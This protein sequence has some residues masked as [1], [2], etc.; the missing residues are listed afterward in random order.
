MAAGLAAVSA[1]SEGH[2]GAAL[3]TGGSGVA[4]MLP[5]T[6]AVVK[7][8]SRAA[9]CYSASLLFSGVL[10]HPVLKLLYAEGHQYSKAKNTISV[11]DIALAA[12]MLISVRCLCRPGPIAQNSSGNVTEGVGRGRGGWQ[13][14]ALRTAAPGLLVFGSITLST[15]AVV[16][17]FWIFS[18]L[19]PLEIVFVVLLSRLWQGVVPTLGQAT[20]VLL[21]LGGAA[22][23]AAHTL[24]DVKAG[25]DH[26]LLVGLL[27]SIAFRANQALNTVVMRDACVALRDQGLAT[28]LDISLGRVLWSTLF[29]IPYALITEGGEGL[30]SLATTRGMS[31]LYLALSVVLTCIF[32]ASSVGLNSCMKSVPATIVSQL[33]P[34]MTLLLAVLLSSL[35]VGTRLSLRLDLSVGNLA[36]LS[37]LLL[38]A[39]VFL[40]ASD[41]CKKR[42][43]ASENTLQL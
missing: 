1:A 12:T 25:S 14:V 17:S 36:G 24:Q 32:Q 41:S 11:V 20:G 40:L 5:S 2:A 22:L 34:I 21:V 42:E 13:Q 10:L 31:A 7:K 8:S 29:C 3:L 9:F 28:V 15:L 43:Q 6:T 27:S 33:K 16:Q 19:A 30:H 39:I 38:G 23:L 26:G 18:A 4:A 35:P 37:L